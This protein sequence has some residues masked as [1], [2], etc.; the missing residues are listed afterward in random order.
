METVKIKENVGAE[1]NKKKP[2]PNKKRLNWKYVLPVWIIML[3]GLV[4]LI[5][6]NIIPLYGITIAF[7]DLDISKGILQSPFCD[8]IFS[9]FKV[10]F[11]SGLL[12]QLLKTTMSYNLVFI[13]LD[14]VIPVAVA[15]L[16]NEIKNKMAKKTFQTLILFPNVISWVII[17]FIVFGFLS[18]ENG[19]INN[20]ILIPLKGESIDFYS[21]AKYWPFILTFVHLWKGIGFGMVV[22]LASIVGIDPGLYEAAKLD[23]ANWWER[24]IHITLPCLKKMI[25]TMFILNLSKIVVSDFGL[26]YQV[27]KNQG[28]LYDTTLT[29][30]VY[31]FNTI[32]SDLTTSSAVS[33]FQACVGFVLVIIANVIVK[34]IDKESALF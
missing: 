3:P 20:S 4:Y 16:F 28:A 6:N 2:V 23:G 1:N 26:F 5:I 25:I 18:N 22:Y 10:L 27:T 14:I 9:N 17:S 30:D 34:K 11:E 33:V 21:E 8:P 31:V 13:V 12:W 7:R 32:N 24:T 19:L 29:L 15:I